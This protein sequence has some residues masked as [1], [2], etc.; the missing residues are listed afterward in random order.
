MHY[1]P[2]KFRSYR[3]SCLRWANQS[4]SEDARRIFLAAAEGWELSAE[5]LA[6]SIERIAESRAMISRATG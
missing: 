3:D 6:A 1:S 2:E 5:L 4:Q